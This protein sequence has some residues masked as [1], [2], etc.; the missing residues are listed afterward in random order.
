MRVDCPGAKENL[1]QKHL[2]CGV[3]IKAAGGN[4]SECADRGRSTPL[5][6]RLD[7]LVPLQRLRTALCRRC[8][9][10]ASD[11]WRER[12]R[13]RGER[14]REREREEWSFIN[15]VTHTRARA[16]THPHARTRAHTR[17]KTFILVST[18][19]AFFFLCV[20]LWLRF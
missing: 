18:G 3:S 9:R 20:S 4:C 12:G 14:E 1:C 13:E 2:T 17:R 11:V 8:S 6:V 5:T 15:K 10:T 19:W 7:Y 16:L